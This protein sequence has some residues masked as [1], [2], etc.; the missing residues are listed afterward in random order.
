MTP[1]QQH[2]IKY[3]LLLIL[4]LSHLK[5]YFICLLWDPLQKKKHGEKDRDCA[6]IQAVKDAKHYQISSLSSRDLVV[7][8]IFNS[9]YFSFIQSL[10]F[11]P[12]FFFW[13]GSCTPDN[14]EFDDRIASKK[15][16]NPKLE[17]EDIH[18]PSKDELDTTIKCI[19]RS[20]YFQ[21]KSSY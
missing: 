21:K 1:I 8:S 7:F 12:C 11:S 17:L 19:L 3:Y 13:S 5:R 14:D 10:S 15:G 18:I 6:E 16:T 9:L 4:Y 2:W 20:C